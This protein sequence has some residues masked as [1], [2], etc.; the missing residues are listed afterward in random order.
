M[1]LN[2]LHY[3]EQITEIGRRAQV[4]ECIRCLEEHDVNIKNPTPFEPSDENSTHHLCAEYGPR[5]CLVQLRP[6]D[7]EY[8]WAPEMFGTT[9]ALN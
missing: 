2:S 6:R 5:R 8:N 4:I 7:V 1:N 9:R 3:I